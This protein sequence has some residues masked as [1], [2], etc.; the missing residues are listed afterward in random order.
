M[1]VLSIIIPIYNTA[2]RIKRCIDCVLKQSMQDLELVLVDDGSIDDSYDICVEY[3]KYDKRIKLIKQEN[4]GVSSARNT[5]LDNATGKFIFFFD[6]DDTM[7]SNMAEDLIRLIDTHDI[8]ISGVCKMNEEGKVLNSLPATTIYQTTRWEA[9]ASMY[10]DKH[11]SYQGFLWNKLYRRDIIEQNGLRFHEE[12]FYNED[13]TFNVEYLLHCNTAIV[14]TRPY[15]YYTIWSGGAMSKSDSEKK[16]TTFT[17]FEIQ[18]RVLRNAPLAIKHLLAQNYVKDVI[19]FAESY[20]QYMS[21]CKKVV[22]NNIWFLRPKMMIS[23]CFFL[24]LPTI[25]KK[26]IAIRQII[27][28]LNN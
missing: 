26:R 20:P 21:K 11:Y 23:V 3:A 9:I 25:Y 8:V 12:L 7:A 24:Y 28:K 2:N 16:W 6:S 5:G 4:Q 17:A 18:K 10:K 1:P 22:K 19:I 13:R 15:Y 14:I 27:S